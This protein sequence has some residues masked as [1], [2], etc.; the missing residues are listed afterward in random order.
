[1][2]KQSTRMILVACCAVAGALWWYQKRSVSITN[3][4]P[5]ISTAVCLGD[6]V[7]APT[8]E[9]AL[10]NTLSSR[11]DWRVSLRGQAHAT[12]QDTLAKLDQLLADHSADVALVSLGT[13]D[14][15]SKIDLGTTLSNLE[16]IFGKLQSAGIAVILLTS[17]PPTVGD[18]WLM[19]LAQLCSSSGVGFV[20]YTRPGGYAFQSLRDAEPSAITTDELETVAE[21]V[22][23]GLHQLL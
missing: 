8:A 9:H 20:D 10:A 19:A 23:A 11:L 7:C 21:S 4:S 5:T 1:M 3:L 18:N 17:S 15:R 2:N 13:N 16:K 14:L 12:T 22:T 6:E